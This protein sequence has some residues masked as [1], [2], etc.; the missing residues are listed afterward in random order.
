MVSLNT[1]KMEYRY[2][3]NTG[4]RVSVLSYGNWQDHDDDTHTLNCV[5]TCLENGINFFDTAEI[6]GLGKAETTLG[7]ALKEIKIP[8]EKIV[9]STKIFRIGTDPND[10]FQSRKHIIEGLKNSLKRLQLDYVDIVF[11]HRF[12]KDTP[13]EETCRAMNFLIEQGLT[14]YWGT[15]EWSANQI[16]KAFKV[17][18]KLNLIPPICDQCQYN[19]LTRDKVDREFRDLF[20]DY[21]Y[22]TTVWSPLKFGI[23]TGKYLND[24]PNDTRFGKESNKRFLDSF[25]KNKDLIN[26][27][28]KKIKEFAESKLKCTA[29]QL[30]LAWVIA[31]PDISTCI[32]G[33]SKTEQIVENVEAVRIYKMIDKEMFLEIEKILNNTP[34]GEKDFR[35]NCDLPIRR[36]KFLGVDYLCETPDA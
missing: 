13:L 1:S 23:L 14:F 16:E 21:H 20:K 18:E 36:N 29:S 31:N 10:T 8:R 19:M 5:K 27:K 11:C 24:I 32:F 25:N 15:S 30:A 6:Y 4:L 28:V 2:L 22:G 26:E 33:A 9:I 35:L 7:K 3:G 12:D 34:Y 17:C